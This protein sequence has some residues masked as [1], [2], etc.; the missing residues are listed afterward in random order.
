[1]LG[2]VFD[3]L[4]GKKPEIFDQDGSVRHNLPKEKWDAWN[5]RYQNGDEFNWR[6]HTG[7]RAKDSSKGTD[8]KKH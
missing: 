3:F 8:N 2:K 6:N 4:F 5:S 7:M 1:M